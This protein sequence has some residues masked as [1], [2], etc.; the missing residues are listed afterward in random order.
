MN[1]SLI[2]KYTILLSINII[3]FIS[4]S[5]KPSEIREYSE[6]NEIDI[7]FNH[8]ICED[9]LVNPT[10][11]W[12]INPTMILVDEYGLEDHRL[13]LL[14]H[15]NCEVIRKIRVGSGPGELSERSKIFVSIGVDYLYIWDR[16]LARLSK[17]NKRLE[18]LEEIQ[19]ENQTQNYFWVNVNDQLNRAMGLIIGSDRLF[20]VM[21]LNHEVIGDTLATINPSE[22]EP[23]NEYER[24][25]ILSQDILFSNNMEHD[26]LGL[27]YSS[28][29]LRVDDHSR[30]SFTGAPENA[31]LPE[32]D[33]N[34][35]PSRPDLMSDKIYIL[36][37]SASNSHVFSLSQNRNFHGRMVDFVT[38]KMDEKLEEYINGNVL[39]IYKIET[40]EYLATIAMPEG[41]VRSISAD[42]ETIFFLQNNGSKINLWMVPFSEIERRLQSL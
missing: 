11:L 21:S 8:S 33:I 13:M 29:L 12:L 34:G 4:C 38:G 28:Y 2:N 25:H 7:K 41:G 26:F 24:N 37:I 22:I 27:K 5:S 36:D 14:K 16:G 9:F 3:I 32:A 6:I 15:D 19:F 40:M 35:Q 39:H 20:D 18:Y 10:Q 17:F 23:L 31:S 1:L 42:D 30:I